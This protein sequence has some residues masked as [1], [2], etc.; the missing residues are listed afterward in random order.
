[1]LTKDV[2]DMAKDILKSTGKHIPEFIA[3]TDKGLILATLVFN[4][5]LERAKRIDSLRS[6]VTSKGIK[7]YWV[8]MEA[9][10]AKINAEEKMFRRAKQDLDRE[11]VLIITEF[12]NDLKS[13]CVTII[14]KRVNNEIVFEKEE[15]QN[16]FDS[17]WNVYLEREGIDEKMDKMISEINE[18]FL[19]KMAKDLS[20]KYKK[21]F[22]EAKTQEDKCK[23]LTRII[24]EGKE[25]ID[26]QKKTILE[27]TDDKS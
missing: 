13:S 20:D 24:K 27:D 18:K 14:F 9:W 1:M 8:I 5:D 17:I 6:L 10:R 22:F 26:N 16:D 2:I 21:E 12:S 3:E 11:E 15:I 23:I 25:I 4:S 7:K 19:S